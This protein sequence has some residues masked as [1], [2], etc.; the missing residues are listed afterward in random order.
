LKSFIVI[1]TLV[2]ILTCFVFSFRVECLS[3]LWLYYSQYSSTDIG[4]RFLVC[5]HQDSTYHSSII[6]LFVVSRARYTLWILRN[7]KRFWYLCIAYHVFSIT[8][9]RP[10]T[11]LALVSPPHG[12]LAVCE[13]LIRPTYLLKCLHIKAFL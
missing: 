10:R 12:P 11:K 3:L 9:A 13:I 8:E 1:C 4:S 5:G 6:I 7:V 2:I